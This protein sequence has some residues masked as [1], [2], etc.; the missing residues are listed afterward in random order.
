MVVRVLTGIFLLI[1][2]VVGISFSMLNSSL[3]ELNYYMGVKQVSLSSALVVTFGLGAVFGLLGSMSMLVRQKTRTMK[4]KK[5][6]KMAERE[7]ANLQSY[8]AKNS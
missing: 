7:V 2:L 6:I 4:L 1:L 8:P 5:N 3:V